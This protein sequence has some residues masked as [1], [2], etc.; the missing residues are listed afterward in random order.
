MELLED[1]FEVLLDAAGVEAAGAA[2][3]EAAGAAAGV[4]AAIAPAAI[5][6]VNKAEAIKVPDLFMGSPTVVL[7]VPP[8]NTPDQR[9]S[10][11]MK[12]ISRSAGGQA[13][14]RPAVAGSRQPSAAASLA[15]AGDVPIQI[16]DDRDVGGQ[17]P[18]R[19]D[20]GVWNQL[21]DFQG[22]Q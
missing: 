22:N 7:I 19:A 13:R 17:H 2:A 8:Q 11:E 20:V 18:R 14:R 5:P 15:P 3:E 6:K 4:S 1:L 10:S 9:H 16:P 12:I 21:P